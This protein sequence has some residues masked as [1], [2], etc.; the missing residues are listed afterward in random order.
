MPR[1]PRVAPGGFVYH[2]LNRSAGRVR[3]FRTPEDFHAFE[4]LIVQAHERSPLPI[5]AWCIMSNHWHFVVRARRDDDL[6]NFFRWLT[7]THAMRWRV[8]HRTVGHG[9]VYQGRF[10]N[11]P[12]QSDEHL[13][14]LIRYV[15]RN[16][17]AAGMV[18]SARDW[19]HSSLSARRAGD[20]K[21][22][23]LLSDWPID[24]PQGWERL[25][26]E[27]LTEREIAQ[28]QRSLMRGTPLGDHR[29]TDRIIRRLGLRHTARREGRPRKT[30]PKQ[31]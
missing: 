8:A 17:L 9:H 29:W 22:L 20:P 10:K 11:F 4:R 19:P 13:L 6:T 18:R 12:V 28:V 16:P 25:V 26:D 7:H 24:R 27:P 5:L 3:L 1:K 2:V 30:K 21:L 23:A 14:T 31:R 15:E